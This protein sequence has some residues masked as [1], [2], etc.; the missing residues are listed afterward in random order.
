M[1][2]FIR[3]FLDWKNVWKSL[4]GALTMS[5]LLVYENQSYPF[6][7]YRIALCGQFI[8]SFLLGNFWMSLYQT[9]KFKMPK[10]ITIRGFISA[11]ITAFIAGVVTY[12]VQIVLM[13]PES[14]A[15]GQWAFV[16]SSFAFCFN[17]FLCWHTKKRS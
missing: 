14:L 4:L 17:E 10:S 16:L 8:Y 6:E 15:Q 12:I 3:E 7:M 1:N 2:I 11:F 9:G 5:A 13:N